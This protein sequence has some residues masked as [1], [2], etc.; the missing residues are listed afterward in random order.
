MTY[1]AVIVGGGPA[2]STAAKVLAERGLS[3]VVVEEKTFPRD[4]PCAGHLPPHVL[5]RFPY[6]ARFID[7]EIFGI[8]MWSPS[9]RY[10]AE[11]L[12]DEPISAVCL[13]RRFDHGLLRLA[14]EEGARVIEGNAVGGVKVESGYA[15]VS[16]R[17]GTRLRGEMVIGADGVNSVVARRTGLNPGWAP[18]RLGICMN[19][20]ARVGD[21]A[22]VEKR[23]CLHP[24]YGGLPGYAWLFPKREHVNIGIGT[25][26]TAA[27]RDSLRAAFVDY[28]GLLKREGL[29]PG[30]VKAGGWR[31][32][33]IPIR[34]YLRRTYTDRVMLCGD[35]AG[36]V[37]PFTGEGIY[38]AMS[39]GEIAANVAVRAIEEGDATKR[40]LSS[41]RKM[42]MEDF[43][44]DLRAGAWL[45]RLL[46]DKTERL[47]RLMSEDEEFKNMAYNLFMAN[48]PARKYRLKAIKA[49]MTSWVGK[50]I[51]LLKGSRPPSKPAITYPSPSALIPCP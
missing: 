4:K 21:A 48:I 50:K 10:R 23:I 16:L 45:Q 35:A 49:A 20:E 15:E 30:A 13:R 19:V 39:S 22:P 7:N 8:V 26:L 29:I 43:G 37:S 44:K 6:A 47:V 2:G 14:V 3:V 42:W 27:R 5:R 32:H 31:A 34:G 33:L 41:Y 17:D 11:W 12:S 51:S 18:E 9:L 40:A 24:S 46:I 38:Y 28:V 1:D 36:F 25:F